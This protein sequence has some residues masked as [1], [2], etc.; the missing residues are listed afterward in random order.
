MAS[1][2]ALVVGLV[3]LSCAVL[4]LTGQQI[5]QDLQASLSTGSGIY[6]SSNPE[7]NIKI[8]PRWDVYD[9][10]TYVVAV[11]PALVGD[12]QKVVSTCLAPHKLI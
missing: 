7:Y 5:A 11:K 3:Y 10:P 6:L 4:A 1:F 12:V 2:E 9:P 8:T